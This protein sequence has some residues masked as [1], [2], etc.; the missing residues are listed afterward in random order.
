MSTARE[1][2]LGNLRQALQRGPLSAEGE[3]GLD[4]R[5]SDPPAALIPARGRVEGKARITAFCDEAA[6]A[7]ATV[8]RVASPAAVPGAVAAYLTQHDLPTDVRLAPDPFIAG[9]PWSEQAALNTSAGPARPT[10][11]VSVTGT[12]AAVAETGTVVLASGAE[13][14]TTLNFLPDTHIA[15]LGAETIVAA[16]EATWAAVR[17]ADG[18]LPRV[19]NWITGPSRTADIE[20][21]LLIGIHG[22]RRQHIVL[23]DDQDA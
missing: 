3:A 9:L 4:A 23:I 8:V 13:S 10:D 12:A 11:A 2:I 5:L 16:Y 20:Q 22:P 19:V 14:P 17:A 1:H 7:G 6:R 15:V 18:A 21:T